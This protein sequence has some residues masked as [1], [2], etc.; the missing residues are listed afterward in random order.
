VEL[1]FTQIR[2]STGRSDDYCAAIVDAIL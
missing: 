2:E 1:S